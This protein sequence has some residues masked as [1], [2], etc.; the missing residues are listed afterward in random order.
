M[1]A[2]NANKLLQ[3]VLASLQTSISEKNATVDVLDLPDFRG[4]AIL[5]RQVFQNLIANAIKYTKPNTLPKVEIGGTVRGSKVEFFVKDN[6]IG[7]PAEFRDKVFEPFTR[8]QEQ[9]S[10]SHLGMGLA[11]CKRIVHTHGGSIR[12]AATPDGGTKVLFT[13]PAA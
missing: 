11:F 3:N 10:T 12:L 9:K 13:L 7:V 8:L 4:E 1:K 6:G 5:I 2:T